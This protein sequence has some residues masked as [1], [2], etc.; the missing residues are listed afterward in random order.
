MKKISPCL[1]FDKDAEQAMNF[2]LSVFRDGKPGEILRYGENAPMPAGTVLTAAFEIEGMSFIALN[3]GPHFRFNEA[4]SFSIDCRSQAEVDYFWDALTADGGQPSQCGWLK[5]KFG[6]SWQ[7]VPAR[8]I[9]LLK[10]SD[11]A[12]AQRAMQAMMTMTR[13][14]I[15]TVEAAADG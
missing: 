6:V 12:R 10:D 3:G 8:M 2:Y 15:A 13:I 1:W 14:D 11:P 7:V 9:E 4:V 5:D